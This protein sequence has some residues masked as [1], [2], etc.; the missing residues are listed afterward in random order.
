MSIQKRIAK[1]LCEPRFTRTAKFAA[2][3]FILK[4]AATVAYAEQP[5][6]NEGLVGTAVATVPYSSLALPPVNLPIPVVASFALQDVNEVNEETE[7][8]QF[9]G[10]LSLEWFDP[11]QTF[12]PVE[13]GVGEKLFQGRFQFEEMASLWC[14]QIILAN[15]SE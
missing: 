8:F 13:A 6:P 7:S 4:L 15:A 2:M 3:A 5:R 9:S 14:P 1:L 12:D 10:V 11:R